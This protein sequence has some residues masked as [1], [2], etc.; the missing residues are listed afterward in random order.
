MSYRVSVVGYK[1]SDFVTKDGKS[2]S[3]YKVY[4]LRDFNGYGGGVG[5]SSLEVY[6][7]SD[8]L[9]GT[10]PSVGSDILVDW[11]SYSGGRAKFRY[12][13]IP[14]DSLEGVPPDKLEPLPF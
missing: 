14:A 11:V 2:I 7:T 6:I 12:A 3:G 5:Y 13:G 8:K 4:C 9:G 1:P 10:A